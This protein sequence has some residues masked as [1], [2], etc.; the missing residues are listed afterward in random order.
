MHS[1]YSPS[2][3]VTVLIGFSSR[4]NRI[5]RQSFYVR[6]DGKIWIGGWFEAFEGVLYGVWRWNDWWIVEM[7]R[8]RLETFNE[9]TAAAP[10]PAHIAEWDIIE[11]R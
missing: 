8:N 7:S 1:P 3:S 9:L 6:F 2:P 5:L 4:K 11:F 10:A